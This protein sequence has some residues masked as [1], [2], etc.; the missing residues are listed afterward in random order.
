MQ[1][2]FSQS[3]WFTI[4]ALSYFHIFEGPGFWTKYFK[5][6]Y[7]ICNSIENKFQGHIT[8]DILIFVATLKITTKIM[9]KHLAL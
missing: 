2:V 4:F 6:G 9:S 7:T 8:I 1:K 3:I 5:K